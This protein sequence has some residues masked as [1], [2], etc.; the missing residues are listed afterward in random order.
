MS[1]MA[2][3]RVWQVAFHA[4]NFAFDGNPI[5]RQTPV[6]LAAEVDGVES[7]IERAEAGILFSMI[8]AGLPVDAPEMAACLMGDATQAPA[9]HRL[10]DG[11]VQRG[12][13][14]RADDGY[15]PAAEEPVSALVPDEASSGPSLWPEDEAS[16][17]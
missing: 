8:R 13:L 11:L 15:R 17:A 9:I 10:L 5:T 16:A 14:M 2:V 7:F 6:R 12:L 3:R 1:R 4:R